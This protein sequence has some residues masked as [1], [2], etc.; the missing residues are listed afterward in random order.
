MQN[1]DNVA[2][3][4]D[5]STLAPAQELHKPW[6]WGTQLRSWTIGLPSSSPMHQVWLFSLKTTT[7]V[8]LSHRLDFHW[9]LA[10]VRGETGLVPAAYLDIIARC[11][12]HFSPNN[13]HTTRPLQPQQWS[14]ARDSC[15]SQTSTLTSW[16]IQLSSWRIQ[17]LT[18]RWK[19]VSWKRRLVNGSWTSPPQLSQP[20]RCWGWRTLCLTQM[21]RPHNFPFDNHTLMAQSLWHHLTLFDIIWLFDKAEGKQPVNIYS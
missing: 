16:R 18:W 21:N 1:C 7:Q 6:T 20:K 8:E 11:S 19:L 14:F 9:Y 10:R 2:T 3:L 5:V 13:A 17:L 15:H 4:L 12:F